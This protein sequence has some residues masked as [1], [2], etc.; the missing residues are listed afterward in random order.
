MIAQNNSII[1]IKN[2]TFTINIFMSIIN[3]IMV[4]M[5]PFANV[6][7]TINFSFKDWHK[8]GDRNGD[9]DILRYRNITLDDI[10]SEK[11]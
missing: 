4:P 6:R 2:L 8:G 1:F 9:F 5:V 10:N 7:R 11:K 3:M